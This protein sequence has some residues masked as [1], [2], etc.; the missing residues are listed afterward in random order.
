MSQYFGKIF[1]PSTRAPKFLTHI[2]WLFVIKTCFTIKVNSI[3]GAGRD[4]WNLCHKFNSQDLAF[5]ILGL[6]VAISK[7]QGPSSRFLG[8]RVPY[9]RVPKS[10]VS[11]SQGPESQ[12]PGVLGLRSQGPRSQVSG[13]DFRLRRITSVN[14]NLEIDKGFSLLLYLQFFWKQ[15]TGI[16]FQSISIDRILLNFQSR[17]FTLSV[18][19]Y[20]YIYNLM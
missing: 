15:P 9:C 12:S 14:N 3:I 7:P 19:Y 5:R 1:G 16:V 20:T 2:P 6:R 10:Q 4:T 11:G 18:I 17:S 8:P 13:L